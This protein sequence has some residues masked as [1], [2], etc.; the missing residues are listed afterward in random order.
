MSGVTKDSIQKILM[1][2]LSAMTVS[3]VL[4]SVF[5]Y[6]DNRQKDQYLEKENVLVQEELTEII[7][8]YDHLLKENT[9]DLKELVAE[10]TKVKELL[11]KIRHTIL[12]Y[13]T[14]IK[15][16]RQLLVFRKNNIQLQRK[17]NDG[18][19]TGAFNTAY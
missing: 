19:S 18:I 5:N 4:I 14:I 16:R 13:E 9:A 10:K 6:K 8:N 11:N 7:K 2:A 3:M 15:Y 17:L 12:D 1:I